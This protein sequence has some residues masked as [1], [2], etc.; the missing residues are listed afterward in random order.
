M[1]NIALSWLVY[2]LTNSAFLLGIVGFATHIP[3]LLFA[4][5]TGVL[6]DRWNRKHILITTQILSMLQALTLATLVLTGKIQ[7]WQIIMLGSIMGIINSF[8]IPARQSFIVQ[9]VDKKEDLGNAIALNSSMF[10]SARLIGPSVA[11]ILIAVVGEGMCFLL[12][13][14]SYIAVIIALLSMRITP[15]KKPVSKDYSESTGVLKGWK[16]GF[17]YVF[18]SVPMR[19][20]ILMLGLISLVGMPYA[21]LMPIIAKNV[22]HGGPHTLGFLMGCMGAG[23]LT[24]ALFLASRRNAIGLERIIPRATI[25]FGI[26]LIALSL[27]HTL[28]V[29]LVLMIITGFGMITQM[30]SGNTVLQTVV[31]DNKRGRVMS[32]YSMAFMG[33]MPFG[34]LLAGTVASKIG[35]PN[36]LMIGGAACVLASLIFANKLLPLKDLIR[37]VYAKIPPKEEITTPV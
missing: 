20:V 24:G 21:I 8:D 35:A 7:V 34:S 13:A 28:A 31:D 17:L 5:F 9:M 2:R 11:G 6:A 22:L 3:V 19:S 14:I 12:N 30:A 26:G 29:S 4:S 15:K 18:S 33:T 32:F 10:N 36:T 37:P 27:S 16:E 1:Q 23:A 25:I